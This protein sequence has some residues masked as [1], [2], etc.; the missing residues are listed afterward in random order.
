MLNVA[1]IG[2]GSIGRIH[3]ANLSASNRARLSVVCDPNTDAATALAEPAGASLT[4]R[5]DDALASSPDAVIIASST[6]SHGDVASACV[7][8]KTPFLCEKPLA[9]DLPSA[10][11]IAADADAAGIVTAMGLNRRFD[12]QYSGIRDAVARGDI[13]APEA[14]L[15]TSRS[16][17]PP[18]P[19]FIKTSGGLFGEKGS[20]FYDLCRWICGEDPEDVF[21][22]GSVMVDPGFRDVGEVDTA[23]IA[24][25]MPSGTICQLDFSWRAAYGQDERLEVNGAKGML[26]TRQ[27]PDGAYMMQSSQGRTHPGVL[28]SWRARFEQTYRDELAAFLEAVSGAAPDPRL[29]KIEDGV[30][31]QRV[32]EAAKRSLASGQSVRF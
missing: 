17:A 6:A 26:Q 30:A 15:I 16:E 27:A 11:R 7:A 8:A 22:M 13:G 28:A 20:H 21:A 19:E 23:L 18:S 2:A 29:A 24:L 12:Y 5:V 31:A 10:E 4:T 3:A 9:F 1:L 32:A 14:I 25:R